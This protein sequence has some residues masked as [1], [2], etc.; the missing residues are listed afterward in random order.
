M[1]FLQMCQINSEVI[2]E[3]EELISEFV[4]VLSKQRLKWR[5]KWNKFCLKWKKLN[6]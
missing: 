5:V 2:I 1:L 6:F 3:Y 4:M